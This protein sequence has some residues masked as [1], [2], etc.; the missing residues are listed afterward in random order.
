M[1]YVGLRQHTWS[2][3]LREL[4]P[5]EATTATC[6]ANQL[7]NHTGIAVREGQV[8]VF[9]VDGSQKWK[10]GTI[11]C[12]PDGWSRAD[13]ELGMS[14][15][16]I[17]M[18]EDNRRHPKANWFEI[19]GSIGRDDRTAFRVLEHTP[20]RDRPLQIGASGELFLFANDL[21]DRYDNNAGV[22]RVTIRRVS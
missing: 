18:H 13:Q 16:F 3:V 7:H 2:P 15:F 20:G 4:A 5:D 11:E 9:E 12:G 22:M 19:L 17:W 21:P 8:Y 14:E 10:D 1:T 6:F